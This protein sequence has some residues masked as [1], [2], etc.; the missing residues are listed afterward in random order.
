[1]ATLGDEVYDLAVSFAGE[2]RA[3]VEQ[4]V[5]AECR[6]WPTEEAIYDVTI[7]PSNLPKAD[8]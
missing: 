4:T 5:R 1:M 8:A 2:H 7:A 3:Y 6:K